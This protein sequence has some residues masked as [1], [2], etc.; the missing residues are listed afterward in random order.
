MSYLSQAPTAPSLETARTWG[1]YTPTLA[2]VCV[3]VS[4]D[5]P[6]A[7]VVASA[8]PLP[9]KSHC[10]LVT[11]C[12][13]ESGSEYSASKVK[14]VDVSPSGEPTPQSMPINPACGSQHA[15]SVSAPYTSTSMSISGK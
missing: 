9:S 10:R 11:V 2:Y 4:G 6:S 13:G 14:L 5:V 8:E 15:I 3:V 1:S 7:A 12:V